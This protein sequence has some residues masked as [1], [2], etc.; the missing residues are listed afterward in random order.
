MSHS[1]TPPCKKQAQQTAWSS[2]L[3]CVSAAKHH[4]AEQYSKTVRTKRRKHLSCSDISWN[5]R[6]D[7]L[8]IPSVWEDALET[9]RRCFS[10]VILESNF[11]P[12]ITLSSDFFSTVQPIVNGCDWRCIVLDLETIMVL[13]LFAFTFIPQ[14]SHHS[15]TLPRSMIMDSAA[16]TLTTGDGTTAIKVESSA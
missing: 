9:K 6:Q 10:M 2:T 1:N 13:V 12:N 15:L 14:R 4:T 11:T 16:I 8:K 7:L 5:T 3:R